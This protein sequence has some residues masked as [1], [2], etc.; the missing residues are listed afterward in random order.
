MSSA[1]LKKRTWRYLQAPSVYEMAPCACGNVDTQWSEY[2]KHLWC[3][4][5]EIDFVPEHAGIFDGPIP[6]NISRLL[7]ISFDRIDLATGTIEPF[8][9][10]ESADV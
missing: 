2:E 3:N 4:R 7:G 1:E 5:C 6:V 10:E 9:L 8:M